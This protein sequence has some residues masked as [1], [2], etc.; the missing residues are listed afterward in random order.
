MSETNGGGGRAAHYEKDF[1]S[2]SQR[3]AEVLR[4]AAAARLNA[5]DGIDWENLAQEIEA[6]G[7]SQ[8]RELYSRYKVLVLLLLRW[9]H[10]P[11]L[12]GASW[13]LAIRGQRDEIRELLAESPSLANKRA[14]ELRRAYRKAREDAEDETGLP[15]ATFPEECPFTADQAEDESFWPEAEAA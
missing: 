5:P 14:G 13:R 11:A 7:R 2:W 10:Q 12:R 6:L 4:E 3:Q 1:Y 9:S 8:L 15:L